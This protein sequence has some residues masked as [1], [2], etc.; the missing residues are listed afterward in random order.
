DDGADKV[1]RVDVREC[2]ATIPRKEVLERLAAIV[3]DDQVMEIVRML[4]YRP[5]TGK[6]RP[7]SRGLHEGSPLSPLLSNL[8]LDRL[9]TSLL[10]RGWQPIRYAD[11]IAIPLWP[12]DDVHVAAGDIRSALVNL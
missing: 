7:G 5:V 3:R 10:G 4:V 12:D 9:D 1:I 8:Y 11:D 6:G 2:F